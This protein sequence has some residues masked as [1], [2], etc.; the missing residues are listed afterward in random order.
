MD[1]EGR[2]RKRKGGRSKGG[3]GDKDLPALKDLP[4]LK[5]KVGTI[6]VGCLTLG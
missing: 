2:R 4:P 6:A 5:G 1:G 3:A